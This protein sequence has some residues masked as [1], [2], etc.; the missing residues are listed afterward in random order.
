MTVFML[1][2]L[3]LAL[4]AYVLYQ[5]VNFKKTIADHQEKVEQLSGLV[6][7]QQNETRSLLTAYMSESRAISFYEDVSSLVKDKEVS[8]LFARLA[9]D[10][11]KHM[12]LLEKCLKKNMN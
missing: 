9:K 2:M 4:M 5:M 1:S 11:E 10:E 3:M 8:D 6:N 12:M 7:Q